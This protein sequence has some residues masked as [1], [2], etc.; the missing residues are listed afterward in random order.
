LSALA[1]IPAPAPAAPEET[2]REFPK[3]RVVVLPGRDFRLDPD[4]LFWTGDGPPSEDRVEVDLSDAAAAVLAYEA[5][6]EVLRPA[7]AMPEAGGGDDPGIVRGFLRLGV[8][9][10]RNIRSGDAIKVLEDG[11]ESARSVFL[12]ATDPGLL[13]DLYLYLGL[14]YLEEGD[15]ALAHIAFKN[16]FFITPRRVFEKGYFPGQAETAIRAAAVDFTRTF[17]RDQPFGTVK[18]A[19]RFV[20]MADASELVYVF[21]TDRKDGPAVEVRVV[22]PVERGSVFGVEYQT[23]FP[24]S[25]SGKAREMVSR[26]MS[27]WIACVTLPS[28]VETAKEHP[29][30]YMDTSGAYSIFLR[31]PTTKVFHNV[32]FGVGLSYQILENLDFF[33]RLNLF[34]SFKDEERDLIEEYTAFRGVLGVG[35]TLRGDWGRMFVH[36]GFDFQYLSGFA[37]T[38]NANCKFFGTGSGF[39][40]ESEVKRLPYQFLGGINVTIGTN[41]VISGPI[42]LLVQVGVSGYFFPAGLQAPLNYPLSA[43]I[44]LGYAFR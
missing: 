15:A 24:L 5:E 43:E 41:I 40:P 34:T 27:A 26:A 2:A 25:D 9:L 36:T 35:Y 18:R 3:R 4:A 33:L 20:R 16:M 1:W 30:F 13:S 7:E 32:G 39:C 44:G 28:R 6:L 21:L 31:Y 37:S 10:Y 17:P 19:S 38:N 42:Y 11:V 8:E 23:E 12:D 14:C 29:Q 22:G